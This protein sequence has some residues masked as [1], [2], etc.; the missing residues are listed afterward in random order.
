MSTRACKGNRQPYNCHNVFKCCSSL[1]RAQK[2]GTSP[3]PTVPPSCLANAHSCISKLNSLGS[4]KV[5]IHWT[6]K[7][8][9]NCVAFTKKKIPATGSGKSVINQRIFMKLSSIHISD[10][11]TSSQRS[12]Y[13]KTIG[14]KK[15]IVFS[16]LCS[17]LSPVLSNDRRDISCSQ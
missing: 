2:Y 5:L 4:Q 7:H 12:F 9:M 16:W 6:L 1:F 14:L 13:L 3:F 11:A 15:L 10:R 17:H 8:G